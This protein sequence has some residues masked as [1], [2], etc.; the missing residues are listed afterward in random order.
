MKPETKKLMRNAMLQKK[1]TVIEDKHIEEAVDY[2]STS[3]D[4]HAKDRANRLYLEA[5]TKTL[6][7]LIMKE[8][9]D[10]PISAQ[11]R[12]AYASP[13]YHS[14]LKALQIATEL[15]EKNR[16]LR[17]GAEAKISAWQTKNANWRALKL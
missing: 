4:E 17:Q 12:E 16:F 6:K 15:D 5:F 2:L 11:E 1:E 14:H 8:H 7:A 13:R 9:S 10:K 3:A